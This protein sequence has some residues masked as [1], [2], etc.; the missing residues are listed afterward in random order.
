MNWA[1]ILAFVTGMVGSL[2]AQRHGCGGR[3]EGSRCGVETARLQ[4]PRDP[5][6]RVEHAGLHRILRRADDLGDFGD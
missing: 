5:L 4:Q 2:A 1:R 6:A 3:F